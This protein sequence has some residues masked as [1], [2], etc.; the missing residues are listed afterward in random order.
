MG[1]G[2]RKGFAYIPGELAYLFQEGKVVLEANSFPVTEIFQSS[3]NYSQ[4]W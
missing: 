3:V 1:I 4:Q 2:K